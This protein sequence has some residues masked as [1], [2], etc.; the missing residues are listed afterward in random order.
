MKERGRWFWLRVGCL[1]GTHVGLYT[2]LAD[3]DREECTAC[4]PGVCYK[5]LFFHFFCTSHKWEPTF[6]T[7]KINKKNSCA[8]R[9]DKSSNKAWKSQVY[10]TNPSPRKWR[11]ICLSCVVMPVDWSTSEDRFC[12]WDGPQASG[13]EPPPADHH[14]QHIPPI[15]SHLTIYPF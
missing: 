15:I 11:F 10:K 14:R 4:S 13:G 12:H 5:F 1:N 3:L 2:F 6:F 7:K 9:N 8:V